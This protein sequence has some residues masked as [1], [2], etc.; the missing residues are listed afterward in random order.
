[1]NHPLIILAGL[2]CLALALLLFGKQT[3]SEPEQKPTPE[4][5]TPPRPTNYDIKNYVTAMKERLAVAR[6]EETW[7]DRETR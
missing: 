2:L 3:K 7:V 6:G 1:M 4:P 5:Y